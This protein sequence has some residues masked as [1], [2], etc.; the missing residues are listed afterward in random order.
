LRNLKAKIIMSEIQTRIAVKVQPNSGRNEIIGLTE[1]VWR[2]KIAATPD[3]GKANKRL[4]EFLSDILGIKKDCLEIL[5]GQT[6]HNKIILV[7]GLSLEEVNQHLARSQK[8][9]EM[10]TN[11]KV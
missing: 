1:G 7:A 10:K 5:K 4:I 3:K 9:I 8:R 6:S 2:I 11:K